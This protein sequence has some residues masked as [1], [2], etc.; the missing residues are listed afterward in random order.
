MGVTLDPSVQEKFFLGC[1]TLEDGAD[2]LTQNVG[3]KLQ[4][5]AA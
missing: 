3:N 1:L 5:Y 2:M 4:F